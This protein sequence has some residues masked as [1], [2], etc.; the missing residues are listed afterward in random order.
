MHIEF[1]GVISVRNLPMELAAF[2]ATFS[3][4]QVEVVTGVAISF[5][6][7]Q[8]NKPKEIGARRKFV[9]LPGSIPVISLAALLREIMKMFER[10]GIDAVEDLEISLQAWRGNERAQVWGEDG[11]IKPMSFDQAPGDGGGTA[12]LRR[13]GITLKYRPHEKEVNI[14]AVMFGHDD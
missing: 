6:P 5:W 1:P 14:L 12:R 4:E 10:A 2:L 3:E 11:V 13:P 9:Q 7:R 8:A